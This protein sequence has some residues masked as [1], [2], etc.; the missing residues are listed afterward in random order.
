[1]LEEI[2]KKGR[3][4]RIPPLVRST[5]GVV[6][7]SAAIR[8]VTSR[9][10]STLLIQSLPLRQ[11]AAKDARTNTFIARRLVSTVP[12]ADLDSGAARQ[13]V[14]PPR[15]SIASAPDEAFEFAFRPSESLLHRFALVETHT[16]L[17]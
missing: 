2:T 9:V 8:L 4:R 17:R 10:G 5:L 15:E 12:K 6:S 11:A 3:S 16:H 13:I 1:M 7:L 14:W